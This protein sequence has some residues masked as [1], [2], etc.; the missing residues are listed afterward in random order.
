[1]KFVEFLIA[2]PEVL[3][4][5][6]GL[7]STILLA[8]FGNSKW[9]SVIQEIIHVVEVMAAEKQK[10][11]VTMTS[12]EKKSVAE[13][14]LVSSVIPNSLKTIA[15]NSIDKAVAKN[16]EVAAAIISDLKQ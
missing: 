13:D 5:V 9:K 15:S 16:K 14:L 10:K 8:L 4:A 12:D 3:T 1:M 6:L 7:I 2:N 11:G